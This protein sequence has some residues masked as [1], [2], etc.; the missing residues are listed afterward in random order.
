MNAWYEASSG[1]E[2]LWEQGFPRQEIFGS[3]YSNRIQIFTTLNQVMFFALCFS[4]C[5]VTYRSVHFNLLG[6]NGAHYNLH[7]FYIYWKI[8]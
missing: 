6:S 5:T 2:S 4:F 1:Q 7:H 3:E 8:I